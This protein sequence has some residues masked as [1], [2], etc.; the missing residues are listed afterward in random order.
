M[1]V[2][3]SAPLSWDGFCV[4]AT[5]P[6]PFSHP[7]CTTFFRTR[8]LAL[9]PIK[10]SFPIVPFGGEGN[11]RK[12]KLGK[13]YFFSSGLFRIF[14]N[15]CSEGDAITLIGFRLMRVFLPERLQQP[16]PSLR[17]RGSF[18]SIMVPLRRAE[19][20]DRSVRHRRFPSR[21]V[22][23]LGPA[24]MI[25]PVRIRTFAAPLQDHRGQPR[26][27]LESLKSLFILHV[28]HPRHEMTREMMINSGSS[29]LI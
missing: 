29:C 15:G 3:D 7:A 12:G 20:S 24:R 16:V 26:C 21:T 14:D 9:I 2:S 27:C 19:Q 4:V 18:F 22:P 11:L 28:C 6:S 17:F 10:Y 1:E 25:R 23:G 8:F 5:N 13:I